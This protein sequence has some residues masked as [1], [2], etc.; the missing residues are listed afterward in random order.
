MY[1]DQFPEGDTSRALAKKHKFTIYDSIAGAVT[2]G[3]KEVA[4]DGVLCI[5]EHGKYKTNERGQILYPR[6]RFFEETTDVFAKYKRSVPVF[7]D[8]HLSATWTDARWMVDRARELHVPF[9]AG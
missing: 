1:V 4:V 7:N 9:M 5:G 6:R 3:K 8:K 2:L